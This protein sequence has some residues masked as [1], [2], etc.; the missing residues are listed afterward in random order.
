MYWCFFVCALFIFFHLL[1]KRD[2][3]NCLTKSYLVLE[4]SIFERNLVMHGF[5]TLTFDIYC[6]INGDIYIPI[7][8]RLQGLTVIWKP[9][10]TGKQVMQ[11]L[12]VV[13]NFKNKKRKCRQSRALSQLN[14]D[15]V[16]QL[17]SSSS[18]LYE[19]LAMNT[20][21]FLMIYSLLLEPGVLLASPD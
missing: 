8:L 2:H 7:I 10:Q 21:I 14:D 11:I 1:L 18:L 5:V 13:S 19:R 4:R 15:D 6:K 20:F 12:H 3:L 9:F 17:V 16:Y